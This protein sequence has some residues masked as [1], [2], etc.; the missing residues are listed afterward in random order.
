MKLMIFLF[1]LLSTTV[2]LCNETNQIITITGNEVYD[3]WEPD[4]VA[5]SR[6]KCKFSMTEII[7]RY[8]GEV[9]F[10]YNYLIDVNGVPRDFKFIGA[11]PER[12][13]VDKDQV[14][15]FALCQRY[16]KG[17]SNIYKG[18]TYVKS[19]LRWWHGNGK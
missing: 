3:Y 1:G 15:K 9:W 4:I 16:K 5:Q 10:E 18:A 14:R 12:A 8:D 17:K 7:N 2:S 13:I 6:L 19:N 11:K